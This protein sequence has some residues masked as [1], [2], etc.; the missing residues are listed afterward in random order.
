MVTEAPTPELPIA[1]C[2]AFAGPR[3]IARGA[4]AD[5]ARRVSEHM[6]AHAHG[7]AVLVF[8]DLTGKQLELEAPGATSPPAPEP[9]IRRRGRPQMGVVAREVT[10]LP[11]HWEWL[12]A[13][14]GGA[15]VALRKLVEER[16][17]T[18]TWFQEVRKAQERTYLF[19][20]AIAGNLAGYEEAVRQLFRR[21]A[22][23]F[24][25]A[26][27]AWPDDVREHALR[28]SEA[29]FVANPDKKTQQA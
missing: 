23:A 7:D 28:L 29:A 11:R 10:L 25:E 19:I 2:S 18:P 20:T 24:R 14:P 1:Q 13:Q 16:M 6:A 22:A 27:A 8:D 21:E 17:R 15:S 26:I 9:V 3:L 4:P 12:A 5:V